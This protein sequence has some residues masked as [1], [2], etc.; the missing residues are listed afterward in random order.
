[1]RVVKFVS[2]EDLEQ[3][4]SIKGSDVTKLARAFSHDP[5]IDEQEAEALLGLN[6]SCPIQAP[7]WRVLLVDLIADY[8]LNH[9]GP[10][11]YITAEKSRWLVER[12]SSNGWV[13][14]R[15]ELDLLVSILRRA[16]WF[17]LS[18]ATFT[19]KQVAGA[20]IHGFGP[21]RA[22]HG[23]SGLPGSIG[24]ADIALIRT[25]LSAFGGDGALALTRAEME[26]LL[27]IDTAVAA[28]G[29]SP[30]WSDFFAKAL[31]NVLLAEHGFAVPPRAV[32]LR[33]GV[34]P[35]P[36]LA[37]DQQVALSLAS[38]KRDYHRPTVEE[39]ALARL[40][41]QRIEIVTGETIVSDEPC[42]LT[43]RL[44]AGLNLTQLEGAVVGYLAGAGLI[45][46]LSLSLG[47]AKG[48]VAA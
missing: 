30:A 23:Q 27:S 1:M 18:L 14:N 34:S 22:G 3:R 6:R 42:W 33:P 7:S 16:R 24:E 38:L 19:L 35:G 15:A 12:L 8:I 36:A 46:D 11:G 44:G 4:G 2:V 43:G 40:E 10:E 13:E 5:H 21:L 25:V 41:R 29:A 20:A 9:S 37:V 47:V 17:P 26:V 48:G 28:R 32:A 45:G 39:R 31:S